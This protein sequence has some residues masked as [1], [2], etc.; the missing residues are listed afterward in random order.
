MLTPGPCLSGSSLCRRPSSWRSPAGTS[1][2]A[3]AGLRSAPVLPA[4]LPEPVTVSVL[5]DH[6]GRARQTRQDQ[7]LRGRNG[8][9]G[10]SA[11]PAVRCSELWEVRGCRGCSQT[12]CGAERQGLDRG[13]SG[14]QVTEALIGEEMASSC[15]WKSKRMW[16]AVDS[17]GG[18]AL[19]G[20]A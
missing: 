5:P 19:G 7:R 13:L 9:T 18:C 2:G 3:A 11:Q 1:L 17:T 20:A 12:V 14:S 15:F 10:A 6:G 4:P 16:T 8:G